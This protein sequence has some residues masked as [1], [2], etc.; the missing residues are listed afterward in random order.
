MLVPEILLL[1]IKYKIYHMCC[2][3]EYDF[4]CISRYICA[5]FRRHKHLFWSC[6][7][8]KIFLFPFT[9]IMDK[10]QQGSACNMAGIMAYHCT[11]YEVIL[12]RISWLTQTPCERICGEV[13]IC[14]KENCPLLLFHFTPFG[15]YSPA[16]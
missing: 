1:T 2:L 15:E 4:K 10:E 5:V 13:E 16:F 12:V 14:R 9:E 3:V 6:C 8:I 11:K 7:T